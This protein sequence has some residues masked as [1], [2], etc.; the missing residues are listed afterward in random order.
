M[1][2]TTLITEN[3]YQHSSYSVTDYVLIEMQYPMDVQAPRAKKHA[4]SVK[5]QIR[6][7]CLIQHQKIIKKQ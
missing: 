5:G 7:K 6:R 2:V 1:E 4:T 3:E